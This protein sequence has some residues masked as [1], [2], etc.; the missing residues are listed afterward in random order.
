MEWF[1]RVYLSD[2]IDSSYA[3]SKLILY[4]HSYLKLSAA[5]LYNMAY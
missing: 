2:F 1:I 4:L 5:S 3:R